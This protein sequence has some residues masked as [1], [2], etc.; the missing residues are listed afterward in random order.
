MRRWQFSLVLIGL[1]P[2]LG[3]VGTLIAIPIINGLF[4][5]GRLGDDANLAFLA[6]AGTG[7]AIAIVSTLALWTAYKLFAS[8]TPEPPNP[9]RHAHGH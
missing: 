4:A 9:T 5:T 1:F 7:T 3:L 8:K 2:A 6:A